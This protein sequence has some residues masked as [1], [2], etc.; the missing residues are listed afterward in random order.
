MSKFAIR[1]PYFI[2]VA[3]L[4][5]AILGTVSVAAHAG[6]HVPV[7]QY[8]C[9]RRR[10]LLFRNA[11]GAGREQHHLPAGT[12]PHARKRHRAH[13]VPIADRRQHHQ[14]LFPSGNESRCRG[15]DGRRSRDGGDEPPAA[16]HAASGR[17]QVRRIQPSRLPAHARRRRAFGDATERHRAERHSQ[18][19]GR[20]SRAPRF[21]SLSAGADAR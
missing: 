3:C 8:S 14:S 6:G 13:R 12:I 21:R 4:I 17:P 11:A 5:V 2:V 15:R 9:R 19:A 20:V 10:D 16:G 18:S 1:T 7:D